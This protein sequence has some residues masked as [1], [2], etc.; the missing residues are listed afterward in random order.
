[1]PYLCDHCEEEL[2]TDRNGYFVGRDN[3]SDCAEDPN[4]HTWEGRTGL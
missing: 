1:M 3:T 4:G 2:H